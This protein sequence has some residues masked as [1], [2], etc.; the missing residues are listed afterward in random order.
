MGKKISFNRI[1]L[2]LSVF[3]LLVFINAN[4][5][6]ELDLTKAYWEANFS[7]VVDYFQK[8][9]FKELSLQEKLLY[10]ECLARTARSQVAE[11]K[12]SQ[13]LGDH[14]LSSDVLATAGIVYFSM[15]R[16]K[17]TEEFI[18]KAL[19]LDPDHQKASLAKIMLLLYLQQHREAEALYKE[20]VR[21]YRLLAD[22]FF[23]YLV[24]AELYI[25]SRNLKKISRLYKRRANKLRRSEKRTYENLKKNSRLFRKA[26]WAKTF[27][28]ITS[29]DKVVV[30]FAESLKQGQFAVLSLE[31]KD[32][33]FKVLLDTGNEVGWIIHSSE[34]N[35]S[36]N[37]KKGGITLIQ[38][39][40]EEGFLHGTYIYSKR[41]DFGKFSINHLTGTYIPKPHQ[42]YHEANFNPS[43]IRNRVVTLDYIGEKLILRT[44]ERF[45]QD[46]NS[47]ATSQSGHFT[48]LPWFGY[49]LSF[50][51]VLVSGKADALAMIETGAADITLRLDFARKLRLNLEPA[52]K[53]V[54]TGKEF[55]YHK[56]SIK[57]SA[58]PFQFTRGAAEVWP[59][60][61]FFNR[62]TGLA[63]DVIIG[64]SALKGRLVL[65]FD[66]F[67]KKI[68]LA[69]TSY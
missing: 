1:C 18:D 2:P 64:P 14:L 51:P 67:D 19:R 65:S 57:I 26:S 49:K 28:V 61:R 5:K 8:K 38:I 4:Q 33:N 69:D 11:E 6:E 56:S 68:I 27:Y 53:Y 60:D 20:F 21:K 36:L 59:L 40:T 41:L 9:D 52:V 50:I 3:F 13:V 48:K 15:G 37:S 55:R 66:P 10:I 12:L 29:K 22:T 7:L 34:L 16:L 17:E 45:D 58:G 46:L 43:F 31:I 23:V 32:K 42:R 63:P 44:K 47:A 54:S 35:K 62:I 39:G 25:A 30:P 24:G